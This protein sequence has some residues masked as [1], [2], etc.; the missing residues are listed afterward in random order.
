MSTLSPLID[1]FRES[2]IQF[3]ALR[4][5]WNEPN[6][7]IPYHKGQIMSVVHYLIWNSHVKSAAHSRRVR[8]QDGTARNTYEVT[9]SS[10]RFFSIWGLLMD[11]NSQ[12]H[13]A[14]G[15]LGQVPASLL[16]VDET[17]EPEVMPLQRH[18][19]HV[20]LRL[21]LPHHDRVHRSDLPEWHDNLFR[22]NQTHEPYASNWSN[23]R[24]DGRTDWESSN[25][26]TW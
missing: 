11:C 2:L 9:A 13:E 21:V 6:D 16:V 15:A 7:T 12:S 17:H 8:H 22:E 18:N 26:M 25:P 14:R 23:R 20:L 24:T 5:R 4:L 19:L 1:L 3:T 10:M